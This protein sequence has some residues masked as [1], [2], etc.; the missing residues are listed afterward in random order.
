LP[1]H[2]NKH[3]IVFLTIKKIHCDKVTWASPTYVIFFA[4]KG[5]TQFLKKKK[6]N[7]VGTTMPHLKQ[8]TK[9]SIFKNIKCHNEEKRFDD[10]FKTM[11]QNTKHTK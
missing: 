6:I 5:Q 3:Y 9:V 1:H 4:L 11:Q 8:I 10:S 2:F 7:L